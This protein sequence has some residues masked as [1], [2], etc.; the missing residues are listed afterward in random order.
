MVSL[1]FSSN[2][3]IKYNTKRVQVIWQKSRFQIENKIEGQSQLGPKSII[4]TWTGDKLSRGQARWTDTGNDN[5][6]S[7]KLATGKNSGFQIWLWGFT[8]QHLHKCSKWNY[9]CLTW[10]DIG[11]SHHNQGPMLIWRCHHTSK[12]NPSVEI[13]SS[14]GCLL[15]TMGLPI[16]VTDP[17]IESN[18]RLLV[19]KYS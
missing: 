19:L 18:P 3:L 5:T 9:A 17:H 12:G 2:N 13:Q 15:F 1:I 16:L 7:P 4:V 14:C 8:M 6:Q 11:W 10:N